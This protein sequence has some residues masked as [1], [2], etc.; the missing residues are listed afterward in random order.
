MWDKE[1]QYIT[2]HDIE[3]HPDDGSRR[4]CRQTP[5]YWCKHILFKSGKDAEIYG[6]DAMTLEQVNKYHS[7]SESDAIDFV[8]DFPGHCNHPTMVS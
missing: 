4:F 2:V 1:S 7:C 3:Y 5:R 6:A 8:S